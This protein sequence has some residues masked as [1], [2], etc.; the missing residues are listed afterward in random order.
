MRIL[1]VGSGGREHALC[2]KLSQGAQIEK[3]FAAP[4]NPGIARVPKTEIVG[5]STHDLTALLGFA[6]TEGIDLAVIGPEQP[7]ADGIV[8]RFQERKLLAFGPTQAAAQLEASKEFAKKIMVEA[9]VPTAEYRVLRS[10]DEGRK[11]LA[12]CKLPMVLKADGLA[13]GKG[14]A[15]CATREEAL[16]FL[17]NVMEKKVYGTAG[18]MIV[19][20]EFLEGEEASLLVL[21]HGTQFVPLASAQDHKRLLDG[22][23][24]PN[25][26]G[27]GA[28]SPA[29]ILTDS[30]MD[31][32]CKQV[33]QPT[34]NAME[35]RGTPFHGVL[36]AGLMFT[37]GGAK[38]L[39]FNVRF[40]DP[41]TQ[42]ILPRLDED[43]AQ[44]LYMVSRGRV[45]PAPLRWK[46]DSALTVVL[47]SAGYPEKPRVGVPITGYEQAG[48]DGLIF[49][50]G[51]RMEGS[52]LVTS[53]G[54]VFN[55]TG[56]GPTLR[57]AAERA[58]RA[59]DRIHFDGKIFRKDIGWRAFAK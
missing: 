52:R 35:K 10:L 55:V 43:L 33:I 30:K 47:A 41:E 24:G 7:L 16:S 2:W 29:P 23:Q 45:P 50:A 57:V 4:G 59:A 5:I 20:E 37:S 54:R 13:A 11:H 49:H 42:G 8:D 40:G 3:I 12:S 21:A 56:L 32:I 26:G 53:G 18:R 15:I 34:L 44:L 27:M 17:N 6:S 39:E 1:L 48:S 51:T 28:Y 36:Y 31:E 22:D 9:G 58:Y 25:T 38:V 14:V 19:A 46:T